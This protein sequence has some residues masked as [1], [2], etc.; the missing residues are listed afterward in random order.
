MATKRDCNNTD[1]NTIV[2]ADKTNK[3]KGKSYR[4]SPV[5]GDNLINCN[6][7]DIA[8]ITRE[9]LTVGF[10]WEPIDNKD[11]V[12]LQERA[13]KY[14]NYCIEQDSRPGNMGLYSAWGIDRREISHLLQG[15]TSP[16]IDTIKKSLDI[17]ANIREKLMAE[18]KINPVT[19]IFWQ[20]NFDGMKDVQ[21]VVLTPNAQNQPR[22]SPDEL[23]RLADQGGAGSIEG[24]GEPDF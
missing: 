6:N 14:F 16:R 12:Q 22:I 20:K 15:P 23:L 18:G 10:L 11:P 4:N 17:L 21:D 24:G 13:I 5:I 1:S 7:G 8:K 9:A 3:S 2:V 19:G